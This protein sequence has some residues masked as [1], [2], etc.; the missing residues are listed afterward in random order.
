MVSVSYGGRRRS[1][2]KIAN[3]ARLFMNPMDENIHAGRLARLVGTEKGANFAPRHPKGNLGK[4]LVP[5][6]QR[7]AGD[8]SWTHWKIL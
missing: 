2:Q 5:R 8:K 1:F 4:R 7:N 6:V 3:Q